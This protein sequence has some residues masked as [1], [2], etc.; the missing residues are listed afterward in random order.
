MATDLKSIRQKV[1][2]GQRLSFDDGLCLMNT[3]DLLWLGE[4]AD[5]VRRRKNGKKAHYIINRHINHT[6]VCVNKCRFCAFQKEE[7]SDGA[8][9]M[10]LDEVMRKAQECYSDDIAEFHIVGGLHPD[11]PYSY[12]RQMIEK[13]HSRYPKAHL[14]A[15]TAVEIDYLSRIS[16]MTLRET[17]EDLRSA[18]LG[19]LPGGGAEIFNGATR[20]K[21]CPDKISGERWLEVMETA[22]GLGIRSNATMLYGHV[23]SAED[24]IDHLISLRELQDKTGGFMAFIPLAFHPLNTEI[25]EKR[26]TTG[27]MDLRMLAVSRLMLDNFDH[28]KAFWIMISPALS[29]LSL[30]FGVDD[31][32]GTVIEEKITNS[33]GGQSGHDMPVESLEKMIREAGFLPVRRDTLYN[34]I[35]KKEKAGVV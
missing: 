10:E 32:D 12:Y 24:R 28:I 1:E 16:G 26:F 27:Q 6:N 5:I 18:G 14:Q 13:L 25:E 7:G 8:Y 33:A 2:A 21:I 9:T 15:F 11:L 22:H 20:K 30:H 19:S 31:I 23:E 29:Q 35:D 3:N 34:V 17:L 4:T